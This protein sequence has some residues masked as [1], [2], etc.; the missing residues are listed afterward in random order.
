MH[1]QGKYEGKWDVVL[2]SPESLL[3]VTPPH[4]VSSA[5][6]LTRYVLVQAT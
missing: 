6:T 4:T 3:S 5:L 1:R 2:A